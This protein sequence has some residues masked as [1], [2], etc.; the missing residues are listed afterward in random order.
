[1]GLSTRSLLQVRQF[2]LAKKKVGH[3]TSVAQHW[4][5]G[6]IALALIKRAVAPDQPLR[7]L[8]QVADQQQEYAAEQTLIV[9]PEAGRVAGPLPGRAGFLS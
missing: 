5:A 6:P 1:M 2:M 9:S 4:E 3:L 8:D 7:V